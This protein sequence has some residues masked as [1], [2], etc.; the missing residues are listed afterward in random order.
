MGDHGYHNLLTLNP[1]DYLL[2]GYLKNSICRNNPHAV[3]EVEQEI[4]LLSAASFLT[5]WVE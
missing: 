5:L 2:W 4:E 1:C 3:D